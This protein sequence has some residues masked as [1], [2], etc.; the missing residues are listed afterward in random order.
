[1]DFLGNVGHS[2]ETH[3]DA[4]R[5]VER[6]NSTPLGE[7]EMFTF[8]PHVRQR[9]GRWD[10]SWKTSI[11]SIQTARLPLYNWVPPSQP[12]RSIRQNRAT[13]AARPLPSR[14]V[15]G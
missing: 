12:V 13:I 4:R 14:R 5:Y 1:L 10:S 15:E 6:G 7:L 9:G 2:I 11:A 3:R 8:E